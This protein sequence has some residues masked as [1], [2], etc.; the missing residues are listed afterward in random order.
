MRDGVRKASESAG[1]RA[2]EEGG[3]TYA[4]GVPPVVHRETGGAAAHDARAK[5]RRHRARV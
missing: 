1:A 4:R 2:G 3:R 5:L